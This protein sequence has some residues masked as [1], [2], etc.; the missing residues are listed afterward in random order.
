MGT[1]RGRSY[2]PP[3]RTT[4]RASGLLYVQN[5]PTWES[6]FI[7]IPERPGS[8]HSGVGLEPLVGRRRLIVAGTRY[9]LKLFCKC[10]KT[11]Q[12]ETKSLQPRRDNDKKANKAGWRDDRC[13]KCSSLAALARK[14]RANAGLSNDP[15]ASWT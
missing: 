11:Q 13:P 3:R 8:L 10:G 2:E 15:E 9:V 14:C 6:D 1:G 7:A 12:F 4:R 5:R